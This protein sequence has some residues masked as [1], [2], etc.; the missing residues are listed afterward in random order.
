MVKHVIGWIVFAFLGALTWVHSAYLAIRFTMLWWATQKDFC[1]Y[2]GY[3]EIAATFLLPFVVGG[4]TAIFVFVRRLN[5][6]LPCVPWLK[7]W[8]IGTT[9]IGFVILIA[10]MV[11]G[12]IPICDQEWR[13]EVAALLVVHSMRG[14]QI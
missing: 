1:P 6:W 5:G 13:H 8:V 10:P 11:R 7:A 4:F 12:L 9:V 3:Q 14:N 2:I